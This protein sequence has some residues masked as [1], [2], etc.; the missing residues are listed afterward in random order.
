MP[1]GFSVM[2]DEQEN[3]RQRREQNRERDFVR[4]FLAF[5]AFDQRDHAVEEAFAG[6]AW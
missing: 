2:H 3:D 1:N 4:R 5:R 6:F